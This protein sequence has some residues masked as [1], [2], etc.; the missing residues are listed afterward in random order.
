[1]LNNQFES[2]HLICTVHAKTIHR[3]KIKELLIELIQPAR[4]EI[5]CLYY[6]INQDIQ[7]PDIFYIIDGWVS[8]E[9]IEAHKAHPNVHRVVEQLLPLLAS[10]LSILTSSRISHT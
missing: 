9:A 5:G 7:N 2:R 8:D 10:A 1:M 3:E 4:E 6:D